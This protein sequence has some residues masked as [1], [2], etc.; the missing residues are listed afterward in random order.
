MIKV[1]VTLPS[2]YQAHAK[3]YPKLTVHCWSEVKSDALTQHVLEQRR[4]LH[5]S[6]AWLE[7]CDVKDEE[8]GKPLPD[9]LYIIVTASKEWDGQIG[10]T[11][12][13][14]TQGFISQ[15][16][17]EEHSKKWESKLCW[18]WV[19]EANRFRSGNEGPSA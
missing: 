2:D 16:K 12:W 8:R 7:D 1:A 6:M 15:E 4:L 14:A 10:G 5:H 3:T 17:A 9:K 19:V 11:S 18:Y 13:F